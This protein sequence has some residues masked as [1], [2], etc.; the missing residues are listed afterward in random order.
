MVEREEEADTVA[1]ILR[2]LVDV[3]CAT[4]QHEYIADDSYRFSVQW[5]KHHMLQTLEVWK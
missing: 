4:I 3:A 1:E 5:A 2:E